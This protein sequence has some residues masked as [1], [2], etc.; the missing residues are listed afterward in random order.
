M[1][2]VLRRAGVVLIV[3]GPRPRVYQAQAA[4]QRVRARKAP[5]ICQAA[6]S[7]IFGV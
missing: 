5:Q 4:Q 6:D 1:M 2:V 7:A 3:L